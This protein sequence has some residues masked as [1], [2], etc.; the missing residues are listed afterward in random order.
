MI[1]KTR[2][3]QYF[4]SSQNLNTQSGHFVHKTTAKYLLQKSHSQINPYHGT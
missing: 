1:P 4:K 3:S 2:I